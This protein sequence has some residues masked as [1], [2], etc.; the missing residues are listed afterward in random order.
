MKYP[1]VRLLLAFCPLLLS[2]VPGSAFPEPAPPEAVAA[3]AAGLAPFLRL[4]PDSDLAGYGF[5]PG[6]NPGRA[7]L[8]EPLQLYTI[9]PQVLLACGPEATVSSLLSPTG[10]WFFPVEIEGV[11]RNILTV[12]ETDGTWAAVGIGKAALAGELGA[13]R[14]QWGPAGFQPRL[15]AIF[16]AS[17][18][19]FTLPELDDY[20]FT[21]MSF[22]GRGFAPELKTGP[23]YPETVEL[24]QVVGNL[25]TAVAANLEA[26]D[27]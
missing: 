27:F 1:A 25:K 7:A 22:A 16:Q 18:Y 9:T 6:D 15:V 26:Q 23:G 13:V 8:G 14:R 12:A 21:P 24:S 4:I 11:P 17:A 10:T 3:A 20:N 19:F 2:V 5:A